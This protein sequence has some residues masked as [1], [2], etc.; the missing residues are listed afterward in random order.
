MPHHKTHNFP[1]R[2]TTNMPPNGTTR[3]EHATECPP[4]DT[5]HTSRTCHTNMP[6]EHATRRACHHKTHKFPSRHNKQILFV[7]VN[8]SSFLSS[9]LRFF[10]FW[11][12]VR[13]CCVGGKFLLPPTCTP[14][15]FPNFLKFGKNGK[16]WKKNSPFRPNFK[17]LP[18]KN[19]STISGKQ[20]S[21]LIADSLLWDFKYFVI[22]RKN[23]ANQADPHGSWRIIK[24]PRGERA[25]IPLRAPVFLRQ[26]INHVFGNQ[27]PIGHNTFDQFVF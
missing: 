2:H 21:E 24:S 7:C 20:K 25:R 9:E 5:R 12:R 22:A 6:H 17:K 8:V 16:K 23:K 3:H 14:T 18:K 11:Q 4:P 1:S 19:P 15:P 13:F 10:H 26:S 27:M